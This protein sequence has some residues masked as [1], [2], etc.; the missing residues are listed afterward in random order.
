[1]DEACCWKASA[2]SNLDLR[3]TP[4]AQKMGTSQLTTQVV[5]PVPR[6]TDGEA[7]VLHINLQKLAATA[8]PRCRCRSPWL[9]TK[10][11]RRESH[12][13]LPPVVELLASCFPQRMWRPVAGE[14]NQ[15]ALSNH[16][17]SRCGQGLRERAKGTTT[18]GDAL[19]RDQTR[20]YGEKPR[21][22]AERRGRHG[23]TGGTTARSEDLEDWG[24]LHVRSIRFSLI[25]FCGTNEGR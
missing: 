9:H 16:G 14:T 11:R 13:R 18:G 15:E 6:C 24:R 23:R 20:P 22:T 19:A 5:V 1:M 4:R 2:A 25:F 10:K 3:C 17:R 8:V 7:D 12:T 21:P